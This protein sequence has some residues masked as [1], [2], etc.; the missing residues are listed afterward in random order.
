MERERQSK[1]R[2]L[3]AFVHGDACSIAVKERGGTSQIRALALG[4]V[5]I[6]VE[7]LQADSGFSA[8]MTKPEANNSKSSFLQMYSKN[9]TTTHAGKKNAK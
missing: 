3:D 1:I 7:A 8:L 5:P 6:R 2:E 4:S 9:T